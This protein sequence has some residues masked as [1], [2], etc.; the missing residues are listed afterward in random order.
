[1]AFFRYNCY[2]SSTASIKHNLC[3]DFTDSSRPVASV[4]LTINRVTV[5]IFFTAATSE[6]ISHLSYSDTLA[7]GIQTKVNCS[8]SNLTIF[9]ITITIVI[10]KGPTGNSLLKLQS[11][12]DHISC[13]TEHCECH[14]ELL[15]SQ[16]ALSFRGVTRQGSVKA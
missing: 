3:S 16:V 12:F 15:V 4:H 5:S 6:G 7:E 14:A 10:D 1:M 2:S 11:P 8:K 9:S 13:C